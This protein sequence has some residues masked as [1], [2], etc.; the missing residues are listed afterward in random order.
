MPTLIHYSKPLPMTGEERDDLI[1]ADAIFPCSHQECVGGQ[2]YHLKAGLD[3]DVA[4][5]ILN[6]FGYRG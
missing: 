4:E 3:A 2:N 6:A 1:A 5:T